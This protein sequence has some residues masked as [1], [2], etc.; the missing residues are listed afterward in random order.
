MI[1][2][3]QGAVRVDRRA[4]CPNGGAVPR[5]P[6]AGPLAPDC[7]VHRAGQHSRGS[8]PPSTNP[9]Q[10]QRRFLAVSGWASGDRK[11]TGQWQESRPRGHQTTGTPAG[12]LSWGWLVWGWLVFSLVCCAIEFQKT[13]RLRLLPPRARCL[14]L[15]DIPVLGK[16]MCAF[17]TTR[18]AVHD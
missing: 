13:A 18:E 8:K 2:A 11:G 16:A 5:A 15:E 6:S 1:N 9:L 4:L 12:W 10:R 3:A 17:G 14:D 7:I